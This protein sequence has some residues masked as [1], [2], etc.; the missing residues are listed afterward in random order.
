MPPKNL[1]GTQSVALREVIAFSDPGRDAILWASYKEDADTV[2]IF[3]ASGSMKY[4]QAV[5]KLM[6]SM[7]KCLSGTQGQWDL[8]Y[9][10]GGTALV[11]AV[12]SAVELLKKAN[13][14]ADKGRIIVLSDGL[15]NSSKAT[16]LLSGPD[17]YI[18]M[19]SPGEEK[20][21]AVADHIN[22]AGAEMI[23]IGIGSEVAPLLA[24]CNRPGR[25]IKTAH[26]EKD[27]TAAEVGAVVGEVIRRSRNPTL[28][29]SRGRLSPSE[30]PNSDGTIGTV[31]AANAPPITAEEAAPVAAEAKKTLSAVEKNPPSPKQASA[32]DE[33]QR[34]KEKEEAML[35]K[36]VPIVRPVKDGAPFDAAEQC[37][38]A[39][40][41]CRVEADNDDELR[42][43][44]QGV[45]GWFDYYVANHAPNQCA[46][47]ALVTSRQYPPEKGKTLAEATGPIFASPMAKQLD[48]SGKEKHDPK[49]LKLLTNVFFAFTCDP[50]SHY[51]QNKYVAKLPELF[52]DIDLSKVGPFFIDVGKL[53]SH[54]EITAA[55]GLSQLLD[56]PKNLYYK[57]KPKDHMH[58]VRNPRAA[59]VRSVV[60][61][62]IG[63]LQVNWGGNSG[64]VPRA[65]GSRAFEE[66]ERTPVPPREEWFLPSNG[67]GSSTAP[68]E[69]AVDNGVAEVD[70]E[71]D[72][73]IEAEA[74]AAEAP[75]AE[76]PAAEAPAA[77]APAAEAP[78]AGAPAAE[79]PA[80]EAPAAGA[81]AAEAPAA[82][83]PAAAGA[84]AAAVA[85]LSDPR[86]K[87]AHGNF[88][89]EKF[90]KALY[91]DKGKDYDKARQ[92]LRETR[93]DLHNAKLE[94]I[95]KNRQLT[96]L[97]KRARE[98]D[99]EN[100]K[101][102]KSVE[103]IR[104]TYNN[105]AK[106]LTAL[107]KTVEEAGTQTNKELK[108]TVA[109]LVVS[110]RAAKRSRA[111][112]ESTVGDLRK[113][114][115]EANE[116]VEALEAKNK[117]LKAALDAATA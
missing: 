90:Y 74:P 16:R 35:A 40:A 58:V 14:S 17:T 7:L 30:A 100:R 15:E 32:K 93:S 39:K 33:K 110:E 42:R 67:A 29:G 57:F 36:Y 45:V 52:A 2:V 60:P 107:K 49:W 94:L 111:E 103:Q 92:D 83:A 41:I 43:Q 72:D 23:V 99:A 63:E 55:H 25:V 85:P 50:A 82:E 18:D 106:E 77:E 31:T 65:D 62:V 79:A 109:E 10:S 20:I 6:A 71:E 5:M 59:N 21:K 80:A 22:Y 4:H 117:K 51:V 114:M 8:P 73:F 48:G 9:P 19:P 12:N 86:Y 1:F 116:K 98:G 56:R 44:I 108:D 95:K 81:P 69:V 24:A 11:D 96:E 37:K 113:G 28:R 101:L 53:G 64:G 91:D 88:S 70:S 38:Y 84:P 66:R 97:T 3:D 89:L 87:D 46:S 47:P 76:A 105:T 27:A 13:I 78:A 34:A 112:M 75:A 115:A 26:V 102:T 61:R 54:Y 68:L 104:T